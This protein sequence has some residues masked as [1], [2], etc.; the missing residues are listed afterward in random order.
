MCLGAVVGVS[1][2]TGWRG[3]SS[4]YSKLILIKHYDENG[5]VTGDNDDNDAALASAY[6]GCWCCDEPHRCS[7]FHSAAYLSG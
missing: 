4:I 1:Q 3:W 6:E 5:E 7:P 2:L